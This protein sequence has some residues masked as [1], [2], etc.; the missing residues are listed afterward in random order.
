[1]CVGAL[2]VVA[3]VEVDGVWTDETAWSSTVPCAVPSCCFEFVLS[4][5]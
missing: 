5:G 3:F 1:M 2:D 4:F